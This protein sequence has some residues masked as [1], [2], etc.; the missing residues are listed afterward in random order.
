[1]LRRTWSALPLILALA[2]VVRIAVIVATPHFRP[3]FDAHDYDRTALSIAHGHGYPDSQFRPGES[4]AFRPPLYPLVLAAVYAVGGH[5]SAGRV[6]NALLGVAV[7]ALVFLIAQRLW[8]R[9]RRRLGAAPAPQ[10][11][12]TRR[13]GGR[14][15]RRRAHGRAVGRPQ[16]DRLPPLRRDQRPDG[17][18]A[19]GH[20]QLAGAAEGRPART[21]TPAAAAPH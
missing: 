4:T 20:V 12:G 10:P 1:M 8:R 9:R 2:L 17:R 5:W 13:A 6:L 18:G 15:R 21:R 19:R 3:I 7:V 16:H 14:G 11:S